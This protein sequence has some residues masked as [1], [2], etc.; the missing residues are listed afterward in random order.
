MEISFLEEIYVKTF[1]EMFTPITGKRT[2]MQQLV[3]SGSGQ[4]L[5]D[6]QPSASIT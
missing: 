5:Y 4:E 2:G 1:S 6:L 3:F